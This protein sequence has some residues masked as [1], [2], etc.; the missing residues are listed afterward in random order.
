M[1]GMISVSGI[2]YPCLPDAPDYMIHYQQRTY[3]VFGTE[4]EGASE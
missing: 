1:T 3:N 4:N 2:R